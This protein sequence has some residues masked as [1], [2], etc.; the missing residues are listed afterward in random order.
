[1]LT[2]LAQKRQEFIKTK[3]IKLQHCKISFQKIMVG[4]AN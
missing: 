3:K 4:A 1:M 2:L